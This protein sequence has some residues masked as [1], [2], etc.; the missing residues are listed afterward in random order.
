MN[1][2]AI[3]LVCAVFVD[4]VRRFAFT[5][6]AAAQGMKHFAQ[7]FFLKRIQHG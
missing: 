2:R 7:L 5:S 6:D 4:V 3:L 1:H